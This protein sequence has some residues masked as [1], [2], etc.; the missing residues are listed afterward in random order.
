MFYDTFKHYISFIYHYCYSVFVWIINFIMMYACLSFLSA[1]W[2]PTGHIAYMRNRVTINKHA[3]T[4]Y[5]Y[6]LTLVK[7]RKIYHL[8]KLEFLSPKEFGWKWPSDSGE[9]LSMQFRYFLLSP[10]G[11]GRCSSILWS[12]FVPSLV[13]IGPLILEKKMKL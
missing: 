5:D 12:W 10:F 2:W 3:C 8:G 13:E 4:N 6:I 11:K 7:G 1:F 9:D